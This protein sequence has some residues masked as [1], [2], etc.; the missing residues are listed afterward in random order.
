MKAALQQNAVHPALV[1]MSHLVCTSLHSVLFSCVIKAI[2]LNSEAA[3]HLQPLIN[4][5]ST[6]RSFW[7]SPSLVFSLLVGK[8]LKKWARRAVAGNSPS[9]PIFCSQGETTQSHFPEC[10][11]CNSLPHSLSSLNHQA[12][13]VFKSKSI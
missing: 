5:T 6:Q 8:M 11:H 10:R 13:T 1:I 12:D 9:V 3:V 7:Q 4:L 2:K